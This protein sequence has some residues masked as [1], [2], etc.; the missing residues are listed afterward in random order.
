MKTSPT[1]HPLELQAES[2]SE[3]LEVSDT[4]NCFINKINSAVEFSN[5]DAPS[6]AKS[7][8]LN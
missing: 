1:S 5:E 2:E 8:P 7:N 6:I 4:I 3:I